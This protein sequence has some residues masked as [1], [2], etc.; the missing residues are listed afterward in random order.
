MKILIVS[1]NHGRL[2]DLDSI[3]EKGNFDKIIHCGDSEVDRMLLNYN[4]DIVRGNSYQDPEYP[5]I[6]IIN[7]EG[8]RILIT[9]G[10]LFDVY[11]GLQNLLYKALHEE[12]NIVCF[13]HTHVPLILEEEGILFVNPG[14]I[15]RPRGNSSSSYMVMEIS[16]KICLKHY[17]LV[18]EELTYYERSK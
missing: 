6:K 10:H 1:D 18:D 14:S 7:A 5:L 11:N 12:V 4:M 8:L 9:H 13:G 3:I 2:S 17:N 16:E 15:S